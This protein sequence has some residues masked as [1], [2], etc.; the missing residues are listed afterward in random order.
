MT[1]KGDAEHFTSPV[2]R[3]LGLQTVCRHAQC[4]NRMEGNARPTAVGGPS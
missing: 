2:I 3:E 1:R 4:P